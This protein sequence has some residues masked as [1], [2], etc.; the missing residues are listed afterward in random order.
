[1]KK[2]TLIGPGRKAHTLKPEDVFAIVRARA[3]A[4]LTSPEIF[5]ELPVLP[6]RTIS[7][8]VANVNR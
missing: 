2:F 7:A 3:Q 1:M 4:G 8:I 5:K 6:K